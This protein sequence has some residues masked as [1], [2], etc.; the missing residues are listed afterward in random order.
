MPS[1]YTV[2]IYNTANIIRIINVAQ[3]CFYGKF[4]SPK[5]IKRTS[6]KVPDIFVRYSCEK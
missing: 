3:R 2:E 5:T 6:C 1:V 4:L